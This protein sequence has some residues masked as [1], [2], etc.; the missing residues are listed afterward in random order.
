MVETYVNAFADVCVCVLSRFSEHI[1]Y[2][3]K[4]RIKYVYWK[5]YAIYFVRDDLYK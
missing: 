4:D 3:I 5:V 2:T 1:A